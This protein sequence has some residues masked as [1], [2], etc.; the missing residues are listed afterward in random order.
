MS[1]IAE[2]II[3]EINNLESNTHS[4]EWL[5]LKTSLK[6]SIDLMNGKETL[7]ESMMGNKKQ[8]K[9]DLGLDDFLVYLLLDKED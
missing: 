1:T 5:A 4:K 9:Q 2:T 8:T 6:E 7:L 3:A